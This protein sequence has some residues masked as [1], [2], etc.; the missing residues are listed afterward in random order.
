MKLK[1]IPLLL[2]LLL[3]IDAMA[4]C[5]CNTTNELQC[6][7]NFLFAKG[8]VDDNPFIN[9]GD[10][11]IRQDLAKASFIGLYGSATAPTPADSF[12]TPFADLQIG[13]IPYYKY[14]KAL[15]YLEYTDGKPPFSRTFYNFRPGDFIERK[16]VCKVFCETFNLAPVTA[17]PSPFAD[18][19]TSLP[20]Y[21]YIKKL[22][23]IG[24][25]QAAANFRPNDNATRA[26]AFL[27]LYR[28][29]CNHFGG[30][31]PPQPN[32]AVLGDYFRPG[33]YHPANFNNVPSISDANF[34][35]YSKTSFYIPGKNIP[36]T[37]E[38][39]YNSHLTE[40]PDEFFP[41]CPLGRGW[42]HSYN[43]Y[44]V[45]V[46]GYSHVSNTI[47][48]QYVVFWP[49]GSI[50]TFELN[51]TTPAK[52]TKGNYD[53]IVYNS[54]TKFT[55]TKK[56]QMSYTFEKVSTSADAPWML[57]QIKD[58]NNNTVTL[59]YTV[60]S[61]KPRLTQVTD[62]TARKLTFTYNG[63]GMIQDVTDPIARVVKFE[64]DPVMDDL[65]K[66]T[67]AENFITTYLYSTASGAE[68]LLTNITLPNGNTVDNQYEQRK[69][70][71]TKTNNSTTGQQIKTDVSWNLNGGVNS[72]PMAGTNSM[73]MINDGG[74]TRQYNYKTNGQA[75]LN[76]LL[77]PT[78]DINNVVYG[79]V[80]NPTLPTVV[81]VDGVTTSY[82]YFAGNGNVKKITQPLGVV[83]EFTYTAQNDI[84]TYKNP[85]ANT[86]TFNYI[87]PGNLQQIVTPIGTTTMQYNAA[88]QPI[89]ITNP[90]GISVA[91]GYNAFG[92]QNMVTAPGGIVS[93]ATYDGASRLLESTDPNG[94]KTKYE[95]DKRDFAIKTI[96]ALN[97]NTLFEYD[98]NGNLKKITNAQGN[99]TTLTYDENDWLRSESFGGFTKQYDYDDE[100]KLTKM[101][102][103]DGTPL[104]YT[105]DGA[106]GN[107]LNDSYATYTYDARNRLKTVSK[108]GKTLTYNYDDLNRITSTVYDGMT[109]GYTY[110]LNSNVATITY[111][112]GKVVTY[113]YD[114]KDRMTTVKDWNNQTTT[115]TYFTDDR[116]KKVEYPNGYSTNYLYDA[117]GRMTG[118]TSVRGSFILT[119]YDFTMDKVGNHLTETKAEP[120]SA[121]PTI[122]N[123]NWT[124]T[125]AAT[126]RIQSAASTLG[127]N[128]N[129]TFDPN[130]NTLTKTGKTYGWDTHDMLTS[131]S[132]TFT[133][134]YEYD[135]LGNRRQATR[136][137]VTTKYALDILGMSRIL[138]ETDGGG[139][140]TN[141]YVY[142]LGLIS[143][144]KPSGDT[145]Y[146]HSDFRGS[147]VA[148]TNAAGVVTHSY[149]YDDF[150]AVAQAVE[151]DFNPFRYVG[152]YGVMYETADL[153]FM[154]ARYYDPSIGRFLSE[155][156]IWSTNLY[157]YAGNNP[158]KLSDITGNEPT[159][160]IG[161]HLKRR[162]VKGLGHADTYLD[163]IEKLE[164]L[165][166]AL[167][168]VNYFLYEVNDPSEVLQKSRENLI[169][170]FGT[171]K[172]KEYSEYLSTVV[173][174]VKEAIDKNGGNSKKLLRKITIKNSILALKVSA[175]RMSLEEQVKLVYGREK[176]C[177]CTDGAGAG[178]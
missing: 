24:V 65:K 166:I 150:G 175:I 18:V 39:N 89:L 37:F 174:S 88:G 3:Q 114:A 93:G 54:A 120:I 26:E 118:M 58:R 46:P 123:E 156:P 14:A 57:K 27:I 143:R 176:N 16:L 52:V 15:S 49:G 165:E 47:K 83:H 60:V 107:L 127:T 34:D 82:E 30:A 172:A 167:W 162:Y 90:E 96:D 157:P 140:P 154:R 78:N 71:S 63:A 80:T 50:Y 141:Y 151:E 92:N 32:H 170:A 152:M 17:G 142:G 119:D 159:F 153:Y 171:E 134:T 115:Y 160:M 21:G 113:T 74:A 72:G 43:S 147:T 105:Y 178:D 149:T 53:N 95:Y 130:G 173:D 11:I 145:R 136:M 98:G 137:G 117:A 38:H 133:A 101:T 111:P 55:I 25:I 129:F 138:M 163:K 6:A 33:N 106:T 86:T 23:D 48:D 42:S 41:V 76:E 28:I 69:L 2:L 12:P 125:Y 8:V 67:D 112:D 109:V 73:V 103:P 124:Y 100:G 104:M 29:L 61:G 108:G 5:P 102:K 64:Y 169:D 22:Y 144:V 91:F 56:N 128:I 110:D 158:V 99:P 139:S 7:S 4:Q 9:P 44:I 31:L 75:Q 131:V 85:R 20:E 81:T 146:Y 164:K 121:Y 1:I 155:D 45:K 126:N 13:W 70:K 132:G 116:L 148:M 19:P 97:Y 177:L 59:A 36:L 87:A 62:P 94:Y 35:A 161:Y 122:P 77:T 135:G 68:H 51:G 66:Y 84:K 168:T 79:D 10:Q 40:L